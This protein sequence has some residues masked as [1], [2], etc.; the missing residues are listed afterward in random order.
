MHWPQIFGSE[1]LRKRFTAVRVREENEE[2]EEK[3]ENEQKIQTKSLN[4]FENYF[5]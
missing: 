5:K 1:M 3:T 4:N 2:G